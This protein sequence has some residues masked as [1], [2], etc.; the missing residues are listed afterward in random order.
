MSK[1]AMYQLPP[2]SSLFFKG[3]LR[4]IAAGIAQNKAKG[5]YEI[6][7]PLSRKR[8]RSVS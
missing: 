5:A 3:V 7:V 8:Y 2:L 1:M 6:A 4:V